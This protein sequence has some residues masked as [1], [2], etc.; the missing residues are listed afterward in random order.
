MIETPISLQPWF[1]LVLSVLTTAVMLALTILATRSF[2]EPRGPF[3]LAVM[4]VLVVANV[5]LTFS[6]ISVLLVD[7]NL[8]FTSRGMTRVAL[9]FL[10][11]LYAGDELDHL[12][13][14]GQKSF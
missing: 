10:A 5:G 1:S 7:D 2:H 12:R 3:R 11:F 13:H 4:V 8:G 14:G 6:V 9:L